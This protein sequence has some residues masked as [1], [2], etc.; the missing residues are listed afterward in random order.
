MGRY[1][2]RR[3][4][5]VEGLRA[6]GWGVESPRAGIVVW[7]EIPEGNRSKGSTAFAAELLEKCGVAVSPGEGFDPTAHSHVRFALVENESRI[8][9]ALERM[10][11]ISR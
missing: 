8:R 4:V 3:E 5:L 7:A 10:R 1:A 9:L 6:Q 11:G 2:A